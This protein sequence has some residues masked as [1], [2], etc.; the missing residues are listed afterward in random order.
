MIPAVP[1]LFLYLSIR[2]PDTLISGFH[3]FWL[4]SATRHLLDLGVYI[5]SHPLSIMYSDQELD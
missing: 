3:G 1:F 4:T 5:T 2:E